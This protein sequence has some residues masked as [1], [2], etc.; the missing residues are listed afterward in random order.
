MKVSAYTATLISRKSR[1]VSD[2]LL[3]LPFPVFLL[4]LPML[5]MSP[6]PLLRLLA[7]FAVAGIALAGTVPVSAQHEASG[8]GS[9]TVADDVTPAQRAAIR[10]ELDASRAALRAAGH[11]PTSPARSVQL[12][13][14]LRDVVGADPGYF[15]ISNFVDLAVPS[16]QL[17]DYA[18][19]ARTYDQPGYNHAGTDVFTWP[20][21]WEKLDSAAV[22][23]TAAA[24]GVILAK[25]DG[26]PDRSCQF[27]QGNWNA[28]Y[29]QHDDG[30]VAW[31]GHMKTGSTTTRAVG[32]R[33]EAGEV[34]GVVGSSGNSTGPHLHFE[35]YDAQDALVEPHVGACN[36]T[37]TVTWVDQRSYYEPTLNALYTHS[38]PPQ[39]AACPATVDRPNRADVF[40]PGDV[41]FFGSYY[42][43][44]L[45]GQATAHT[46]R[47]PDGTTAWTWTSALQV[48][49]YAASWWYYS[50]LL[51]DNAPGGTWTY[52]AV[53]E[54][55]TV[56]RSFMVDT[57]VSSE[58]DAAGAVAVSALRPNPTRGASAVEVT[59]AA[60]AEARVAVV[61]ALGRTVA[62]AHDG[63]LG[64]GTTRIAVDGQR[65][66]PGVYTV[67]IDAGDVRTSRR[68][69]LAR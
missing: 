21:G 66:P 33:V 64:A 55:Q 6:H 44:Q 17:L 47:R 24:A 13:W 65:L 3:V 29:V 39:F 56:T 67:R 34:L 30:A 19:G 18:C 62:V 59:L 26:N 27:G 37:A 50:Q 68:L 20:F 58:G 11:L 7:P 43:D 2:A 15:G 41:V 5:P 23:I 54:G 61:D 28:V 35:L 14:P 53:Y 12:A 52:E 25:A 4:V 10:A 46:V 16:G 49:H 38:A 57:G 69:V 51:P 36:A 40:V 1:I 31:Y 9:Y 42:R 48:P 8:H 63:P 60:P 45:Q 32:E 22:A